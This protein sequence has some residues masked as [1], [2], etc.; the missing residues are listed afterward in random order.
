M[1]GRREIA[2]RKR[3]ERIV[4]VARQLFLER[5]YDQST[6]LEI[7]KACEVAVGTIYKHFESKER[8]L[9]GVID[10]QMRRLQR[11][12]RRAVREQND[13]LSQ[14]RVYAALKGRMIAQNRPLFQNDLQS[15]AIL[16]GTRLS[17]FETSQ[18]RQH[19]FFL[20]LA[21]RM[22]ATG[23]LK[24][25]SRTLYAHLMAALTDGFIQTALEEDRLEHRFD[26]QLCQVLLQ[27]AGN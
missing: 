19:T 17:N 27:G 10:H 11:A 9:I 21:D 4:Q 15:L 1:R 13:P 3:E 26:E 2:L 18:R 6:V 20:E 12:V 23:F 22:M 7:A 24:P 16:L 5:G 8:L 14:L 25:G